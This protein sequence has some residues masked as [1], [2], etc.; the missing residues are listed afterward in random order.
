MLGTFAAS[1]PIIGSVRDAS[2]TSKWRAPAIFFRFTAVEVTSRPLY[3]AP[4]VLYVIDDVDAR[5]AMQ[6]TGPLSLARLLA[7]PSIRRSRI[8]ESRGEWQREREGGLSTMQCYLHHLARSSSSSSGEQRSRVEKRAAHQKDARAPNAHHRKYPPAPPP[9]NVRVS[10]A[11]SAII[12]L[13][14]A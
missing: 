1:L 12:A 3:V 9:T 14:H 6:P 7:R 2:V 13:A 10:A 11:G 5:S 4:Y 8:T